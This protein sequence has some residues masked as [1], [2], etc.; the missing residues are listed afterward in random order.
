MKKLALVLSGLAAL[1]ALAEEEMID[2][3]D[4]TR[5]YTQAAVFVT[6]DADIRTSGMFTGAWSENIQ[7]AGFIEANWGDRSAEKGDNFGIDYKSGRA[8]YFQVHAIGDGQGFMPRAGFSV[9]YIHQDVRGGKDAHLVAVG[10]IGLMNPKY[11]AGKAMVFPNVAYAT[12]SING[13]QV[14]GY[15]LNLFATV[16]VGNSGAFA[17]VWPEYFSVSGDTIELSSTTY[18]AMLNA[19]I[20]KD[21]KTWLMTKLEYNSID[22][23]GFR[24][25]GDL[26][27]EIGLKWFL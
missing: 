22:A 6:S 21:R 19:P 18:N 4:L 7:F 27:A 8:Q 1:P 2:P 25:D 24:S 20:S 10:G 26:K 23:N 5:V 3:S 15:M 12:G 9:D 14:D 16:P 17:M 13:E 11:T